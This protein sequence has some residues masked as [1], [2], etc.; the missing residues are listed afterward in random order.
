VAEKGSIRV[1]IVDDDPMFLDAVEAL[2]QR[3]EGIEVVGRAANGEEAL[4]RTAELLPD[5][6]TMDLEMPVMNGAEATRIIAAYFGIPIVLLTGSGSSEA[7]Q[8]ALAA[9]AV[10]HV[11]KSNAWGSLVP[12]LRAAAARRPRQ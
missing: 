9:G 10:A 8:E 5:V 3:V 11:V 7:I 1:L 2:V 6:V 4:R 12:T